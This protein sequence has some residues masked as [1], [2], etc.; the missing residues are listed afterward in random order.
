MLITQGADLNPES[1]GLL[2]IASELT[3]EVCGPVPPLV[4]PCPRSKEL[5]ITRTTLITRGHPGDDCTRAR[6]GVE[7]RRRVR[8]RP[9]FARGEESILRLLF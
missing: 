3:A 4:A 9:I 2:D 1:P 6:R 8:E 7:G 5:T